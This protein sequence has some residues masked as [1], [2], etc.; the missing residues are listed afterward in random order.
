MLVSFFKIAWRNLLKDKLFSFINIIGLSIGLSAFMILAIYISYE[1]S[2][3]EMW[4]KKDRIFRFTYRH[5]RGDNIINYTAVTANSIHFLKQFSGIDNIVR[6]Q[7]YPTETHPSNIITFYPENGKEEK[8]FEEFRVYQAEQ[9]FLEIFDFKLLYGDRSTALKF[10]NSIVISETIAKKYF[11]RISHELL[12][13]TLYLDLGTEFTIR[14]IYKNLPENSHFKMDILLSFSTIWDNDNM[15][16]EFFTYLLLKKSVNA[17]ILQ[18]ELQYF[19]DS[20]ANSLNVD[21]YGKYFEEKVIHK[22]ELQPLNKIYL[23]EAGNRNIRDKGNKKNLVFLGF[24]AIVILIASW[25]NYINLS[26][27]KMI[28]RNREIGVRKVVGANRRSLFYQFI[29]EALIT[30]GIAFIVAVNLISIFLVLVPRIMD[31]EL[32]MA[33][34]HNGYPAN[35]LFWLLILLLFAFGSMVTG[36]IPVIKFASTRLV[37]M[38]A[39]F[40][41]QPVR[42]NKRVLNTR[43]GF[44]FFQFAIAE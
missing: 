21:I 42:Q 24:V 10:P 26:L 4:P 34:W 32:E 28:N 9:P 15:V 36:F 37:V 33:I 7:R 29:T 16:S 5:I 1:M 19:S 30:N 38:L 27:V 14:G 6:I 31:K 12:G 41:Y 44:V 35:S 25:I 3:D 23:S 40:D 43:N 22:I 11:G 39:R 20:I 13:K 18:N 8:A 2:Y 17:N